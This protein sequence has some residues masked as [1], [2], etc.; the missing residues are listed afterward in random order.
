MRVADDQL[1]AGIA[2]IER[3]DRRRAAALLRWFDEYAGAMR[4]H[5]RVEDEIYFSA[6]AARVPSYAECAPLMAADHEQVVHLLDHL[7]STLAALADAGGRCRRLQGDAL[8]QAGELRDVLAAHLDVED[9]DVLPLFGRH[10]GADEFEAIE[11]QALNRLSL[12][13]LC[14]IVPWLATTVQPAVAA[15]DLASAPRAIRFIWRVTRRRYA[16]L[17][18]RAFATSAPSREQA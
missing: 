2:G 6:L 18:H 16:R 1:V 3:G 17:A 14:F 12:R 5:L 11:A 13:Q 15:R 10:F 9:A 4:L 8:A 7:R